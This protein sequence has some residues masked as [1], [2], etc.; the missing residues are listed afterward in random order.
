MRP[1]GVGYQPGAL[2]LLAYVLQA[3]WRRR[4]GTTLTVAG[5][6]EAGGIHGAVASEAERVYA[7]FPDETRETTRRVMLRLVSVGP[8]P[9]PVRRAVPRPALVA[10]LDAMAAGSVLARYTQARL[11]TADTGGVEISHEALLDAW[12]RL[13]DWVAEDQAGLRLHRQL[14][15]D[16]AS[17]AGEQRDP[18]GLYRGIPGLQLE[19]GVSASPQT[20]SANG[21]E[22]VVNRVAFG[23][24]GSVLVSAN[25][26]GTAQV[27]DTDPADAV[28][29]LCAVLGGS[30]AAS[31]WSELDPSPGRD[32]CSPG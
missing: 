20:L 19:A 11:I 32:P 30:S 8:G 27:W 24:G 12:P 29:G 14:A 10:G 13:R 2:P 4:A 25:S 22:L 31:Q 18:G 7:D 23:A 1:G 21:A 26:D 28:R 9:R 16:A 3:T 6:R 15:E 17:W 5:Y